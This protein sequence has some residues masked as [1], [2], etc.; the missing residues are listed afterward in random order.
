MGFRKEVG[1]TTM[2]R[3][4]TLG[5][6]IVTLAALPALAADL[7]PRYPTK[8]PAMVTSVYN[9]SGCYIGGNI[10][11]KWANTTDTVVIADVPGVPFSGAT[12]VFARERAST[13][14]GGGQLGCNWQAPGS[15]WVLGLEGDFD[16]QRWRTTRVQPVTFPPFVV[17]DS[18]TA[19]SDWQA[20]ARARLGYAWDRTLLYVTGGAA[21]TNVKVGTNFPIFVGAVVFPATSAEDS[22]TLFGATFGGGFEHAFSNNWSFGVEARYSWY[23]N[24]TFNG[25]VVASLPAVGG[26]FLFAPVTQTL[27]IETFEVTGRLN[28]RFDWGGPVVAR[29]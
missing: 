19:R 4:L 20:S 26:G 7:P 14:I 1:T 16:W 18:F 25:G 6:G 9:W 13:F 10:G 24:Q 11:G 29:Y 8:A 21:F 17:G 2:K 15:N 12:S 5:I 28:Y 22:K 27:K 23:G 3:A